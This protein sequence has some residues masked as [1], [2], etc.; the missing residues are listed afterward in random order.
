MLAFCFSLAHTVASQGTFTGRPARLH[1]AWPQVAHSCIFILREHRALG[2][3]PLGFRML[4]ISK[5]VLSKCD[6]TGHRPVS[7]SAAAVCQLQSLLKGGLRPCQHCVESL[8]ERQ[9]LPLADTRLPAI[10][11]LPETWGWDGVGGSQFL[12]SLF[13]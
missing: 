12:G 4:P 13:Q 7:V 11:S 8:S 9:A 6:P 10:F 1:S 2:T 3:V 5:T